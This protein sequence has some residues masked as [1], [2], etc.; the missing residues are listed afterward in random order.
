MVYL[1]VKFLQ[2]RIAWST[3]HGPNLI[4]VSR[5]TIMITIRYSKASLDRD[6][7]HYPYCTVHASNK[8]QRTSHRHRIWSALLPFPYSL[9]S[10]T[11]FTVTDSMR[12]KTIPTYEFG[13]FLCSVGYKP[14]I[15]LDS[16][17]FYQPQ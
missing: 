16:G 15:Q 5:T 6:F 12:L 17:N 4:R 8:C 9:P 3:G 2:N 7:G 1:C 10:L 11:P 14:P 13:P